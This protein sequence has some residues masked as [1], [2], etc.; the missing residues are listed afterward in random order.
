M[1]AIIKRQTKG[2]KRILDRGLYLITELVNHQKITRFIDS[3]SH[4]RL[5]DAIKIK[6]EGYILVAIKK[7]YIRIVIAGRKD[8]RSK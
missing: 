3:T 5:F 2:G 7:I 6:I 8:C 1:R 4:R